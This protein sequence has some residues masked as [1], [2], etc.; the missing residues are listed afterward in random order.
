MDNIKEDPKARA[1]IDISY[2]SS[3]GQSLGTERNGDGS[4]NLV[5][6]IS[7]RRETRRRR[8][9]GC[10][11]RQMFVGAGGGLVLHSRRRRCRQQSAGRQQGDRQTDGQTDNATA[12]LP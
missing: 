12:V 10:L 9:V 11:G 6:N 7:D 5:V 3:R 8:G 4:Y 1:N 2:G